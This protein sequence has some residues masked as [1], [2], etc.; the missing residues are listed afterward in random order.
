MTPWKRLDAAIDAHE[1]AKVRV[2]AA[3]QF[4]HLGLD[5]AR[6]LEVARADE[7]A[8]AVYRAEAQAEVDRLAREEAERR[9]VIPPERGDHQVLYVLCRLRGLVPEVWESECLR[10]GEEGRRAVRHLTWLRELRRRGHDIKDW[11]ARRCP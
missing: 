4:A 7:R 1:R 2:L 6:D 8:Q 3:Q 9:R 5:R 11:I 10:R